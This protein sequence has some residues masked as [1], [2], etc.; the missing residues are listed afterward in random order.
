MRLLERVLSHVLVD[1]FPVELL[2]VLPPLL[3]IQLTLMRLNNI[4][5]FRTSTVSQLV[6]VPRQLRINH[7]L[8]LTGS[9]FLVH[10]A[11]CRRPVLLVPCIAVM[12]HLLVEGV[13]GHVGERRGLFLAHQGFKLSLEGCGLLLKSVVSELVIGRGSSIL[14]LGNEFADTLSGQVFTVWDKI[15]GGLLRFA[16]FLRRRR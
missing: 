5:A 13:L 9:I 7:T 6:A 11:L 8:Y 15:S 1:H 14:H 4:G 2:E 10:E 3:I 16:L 12:H